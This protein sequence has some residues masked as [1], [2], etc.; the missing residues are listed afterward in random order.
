MERVPG[1]SA[2]VGTAG[3]QLSQPRAKNPPWP[4]TWWPSSHLKL[5]RGWR[6]GRGE[7]AGGSG[8]CWRR[9]AGPDG[10]GCQAGPFTHH[11][12]QI[13]AMATGLAGPCS[14]RAELQARGPGAGSSDQ[15]FLEHWL[16]S[17]H[18]KSNWLFLSHPVNRVSV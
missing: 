9:A 5:L 10:R 4:E 18:T 6:G 17:G 1:E 13:T 7:L 15:G 14:R 2:R 3:N 16:F 8:V 12:A 11:P